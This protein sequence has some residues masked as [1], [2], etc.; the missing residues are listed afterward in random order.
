[1]T[2]AKEIYDKSYYR[3][4]EASNGSRLTNN[5]LLAWFTFQRHMCT[6]TMPILH[7]NVVQN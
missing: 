3:T 4:D 2:Y 5:I 7:Q 1:M 6:D